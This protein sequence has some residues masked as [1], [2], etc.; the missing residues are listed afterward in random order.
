MNY[1]ALHM[2]GDRLGTKTD[3]DALYEIIDKEIKKAFPK[4]QI[5]D[6]RELFFV[7][8]SSASQIPHE[9]PKL[10]KNTSEEWI[11]SINK[12]IRYVGNKFI[13]RH[14]CSCKIFEYGAFRKRRRSFQRG[15]QRRVHLFDFGD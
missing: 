6:T 7:A 5:P 15:N 4:V 12:G 11:A 3:K 8:S 13:T 1:E 14:A 9:Q 2:F 10:S